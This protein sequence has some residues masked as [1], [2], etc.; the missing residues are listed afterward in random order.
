MRKKIVAGNWKMHKTFKEGIDLIEECISLAEEKKIKGTEIIFCTPFIHLRKASKLTE[1]LKHIHTGAQNCHWE[2]QGAFTGETSCNMIESCG[3]AYVIVGHSE[4]RQYFNETDEQL[5]KNVAAVL[6]H[7][8]TP[9]FCCGESLEIREANTHNELVAKQIRK[10]LFHLDK[11]AIAKVVIAYE[12]VW[13]IGTGKT[14]SI[15]QAQEMHNFIRKTISHQ[16]DFET[17]DSISILFG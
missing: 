12:P 17:A 6:K 8:L 14:A 9:I 16:Y 5:A 10:S 13:A 3:A 15:A 7:N 11:E 4:R 2:E 1:D